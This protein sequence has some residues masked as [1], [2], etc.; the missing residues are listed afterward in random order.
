L[1]SK[2]AQKWVHFEPKNGSKMAQ[3]DP[4]LGHF[5]A[6]FGVIFEPLLDQF[7]LTGP[8]FWAQKWLKNGVKNGPKMGQKWGILTPFLTPF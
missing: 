1:G 6:I 2:V 8:R 5:W 3:N 4:F 7:R